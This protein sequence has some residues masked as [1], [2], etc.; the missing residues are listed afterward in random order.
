MAYIAAVGR[1]KSKLPPPREAF[2]GIVERKIVSVNSKIVHIM[3]NLKKKSKLTYK[4]LFTGHSGKSDL[5]ATFLA[6]L[7]LIKAK[8]VRV[9]G[10]GELADIRLIDSTELLVNAE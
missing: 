6:L 3:K 7:E 5:V 2:S 9:E 10:D 1:G 4:S 8:R